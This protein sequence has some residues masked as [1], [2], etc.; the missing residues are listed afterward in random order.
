MKRAMCVYL[1][2]W[3]L[4]RLRHERPDLR[5]HPIAIAQPRTSRGAAILFCNR[6]SAHAGIR[7]GMPV[8]EARAREPG[9]RLFETD[10]EGDR[11]R[12]EQLAKWAEKFSP[13]VGLEEGP[14]PH[15]L[16]L[17]VTG[18]EACFRGDPRLARLMMESLKR[19]GWVARLALADTVGAAWGLAHYGAKIEES[20]RT[21][22]GRTRNLAKTAYY[23]R[24]SLKPSLHPKARHAKRSRPCRSPR[25]VCR[26][27]RWTR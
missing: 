5:D 22:S 4:Q 17:D 14:T 16:L 8:A 23:V 1:P 18:C 7:A 21:V 12:L 11:E 6:L 3:P 19:Q 25:C 26:R 24:G 2:Q 27:T 20:Q 9:I 10:P 15:C 13:R